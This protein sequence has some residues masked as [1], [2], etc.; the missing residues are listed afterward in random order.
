MLK[1]V[2]RSN[3]STAHAAALRIAGSA[4]LEP[5]KNFLHPNMAHFRFLPGLQM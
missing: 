1:S 4:D 2:R 5:G 3:C